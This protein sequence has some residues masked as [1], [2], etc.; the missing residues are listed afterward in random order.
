MSLA[1][2]EVGSDKNHE[3]PIVTFVELNLI[4]LKIY[5][6]IYIGIG[7][8]VAENL[9]SKGCSILVLVYTSE[10]SASKGKVNIIIQIYTDPHSRK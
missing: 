2:H 1:L 8:A 3:P 9:A 6:S 5:L 4:N 7:A 10:S